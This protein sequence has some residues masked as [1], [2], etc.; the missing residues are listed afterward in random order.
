[1][2]SR[3]VKKMKNQEIKCINPSADTP[4][5][6]L[7]HLSRLPMWSPM[8]VETLRLQ[9]ASP[10]P[11]HVLFFFGGVFLSLEICSF[12]I[13]DSLL[14]ITLAPQVQSDASCAHTLFA[15][16]CSS[17]HFTNDLCRNSQ[18]TRPGHFHL[19]SLVRRH[20]TNLIRYLSHAADCILNIG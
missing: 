12:I 18:M 11:L 6:P 8:C 5:R 4:G 9:A 15:N 20:Y 3:W 16:G 7:M 13:H 14:E 19:F 1:M 17:S 10:S 2:S